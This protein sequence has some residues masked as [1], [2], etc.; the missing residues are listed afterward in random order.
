ME[1]L[2]VTLETA[3]RLKAAGFTLDEPHMGWQQFEGTWIAQDW[4]EVDEDMEWYLAP[5][6]QEIADQLPS[7]WSIG[8][9]LNGD[10]EAY[11][12]D[13][14]G[15]SEVTDEYTANGPTMAEA[16]AALWLTQEPTS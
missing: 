9:G 10:Y 8:S 15:V 11:T 3:Q 6:A 16:L 12:Q 4:L 5:T 7:I 13:G 1:P 2:V 14:D